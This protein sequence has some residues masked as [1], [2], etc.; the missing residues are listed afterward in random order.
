MSQVMVIASLLHGNSE[1]ILS[2]FYLT[3]LFMFLVIAGLVILASVQIKS[4][5][6]MG[7]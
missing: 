4:A 7:A 5:L 6:R 1:L 3:G 2:M